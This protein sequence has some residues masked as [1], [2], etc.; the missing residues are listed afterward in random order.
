MQKSCQG[1]GDVCERSEGHCHAFKDTVDRPEVL[2]ESEQ[3]KTDKSIPPPPV[4]EI[5]NDMID[6]F[7]AGL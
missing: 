3:T 6:L 1:E 2:N 7:F 4:W 5:L